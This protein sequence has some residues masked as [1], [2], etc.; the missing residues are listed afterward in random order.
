MS[1]TRRQSDPEAPMSFERYASSAELG[2]VVPANL[3]AKR[4]EVLER[5]EDRELIW[6]IQD[7]SRARG[8]IGAFARQVLETFRERLGTD[9]MRRLGVGPARSY[10][11]REVAEARRMMPNAD[12]FLTRGERSDEEMTFGSAEIAARPERIPASDLLQYCR[13]S[14]EQDLERSICDLCL[15][16]AIDP[17]FFRPWY[18]VELV[19]CLRE[20]KSTQ[21]K[22]AATE[23]VRTEVGRRVHEEIDYA[24]SQRGMVLIEGIERIG[25]TFAAKAWAQIHPGRARYFQVPATNDDI[26][27]FR[28]IAAA[29][30]VSIN[31]NSKAHQ[32]RDRIEQVLQSGQ[33]ALIADE[34][35][36]IWPQSRYRDA[37]PE[38]LNWLLN[39]LVNHGVPVI[40]ICTPQF[41]ENAAALKRRVAW[42]DGQFI[43]RLKQFTQLPETLGD[44]D[45]RAVSRALLPE[46]D[47]ASVKLLVAYAKASDRYLAGIDAAVSRARYEAKRDGVPISAEIVAR[48]IQGSAMPSDNRLAAAVSKAMGK[49]TGR[50][51]AAPLPSLP[52]LTTAA[53]PRAVAPASAEPSHRVNTLKPQ[54]LVIK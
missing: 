4:C 18:F 35:H 12:Q 21:A 3:V 31:L 17:A 6:W 20:F 11:A 26:G 30:G 24:V 5:D 27:F 19:D 36:M 47:A 9:G 1:N 52:D 25:K 37:L 48:V 53:A 50:R 54:P 14:A 22:L 8:G 51:A 15:D 39:A 40:L 13:K 32:L 28:A 2:R 41:H 46:A 10:N 38:R 16:H 45:L 42:R 43:G 33:L 29:L 7:R 34:A 49:Q 44:D 23:F